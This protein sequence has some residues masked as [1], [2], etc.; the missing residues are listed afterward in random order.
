MQQTKYNYFNIL[1]CNKK[2]LNVVNILLNRNSN[3]LLIMSINNNLQRCHRLISINSCTH[4]HTYNKIRIEAFNK[5]QLCVK[6]V[7]EL[8]NSNLQQWIRKKKKQM[9][10]QRI[11]KQHV[12]SYYRNQ[13]FYPAYKTTPIIRERRRRRSGSH[14]FYKIFME[15]QFMFFGSIRYDFRISKL[16]LFFSV[17]EIVYILNKQIENKFIV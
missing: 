7:Y 1:K 9:D 10:K 12:A 6:N 3:F 13:R 5:K 4:T 8:K 16:A 17:Y 15:L 11:S 2:S 14:T